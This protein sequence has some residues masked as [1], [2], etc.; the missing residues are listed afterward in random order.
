MVEVCTSSIYRVFHLKTTVTTKRESLY[1]Q[2]NE[3]NGNIEILQ[4]YP[5]TAADPLVEISM[6]IISAVCLSVSACHKYFLDPKFCCRLVYCL[7]WYFL[8]CAL[9]HS[10]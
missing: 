8:G 2:N 3:S 7:I 10:P 9:L 5:I 4:P 6:A 1:I